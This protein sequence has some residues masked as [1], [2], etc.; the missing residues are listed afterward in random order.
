[1]AIRLT[2]VR[3]LRRILA[4]AEPKIR[5]A[6]NKEIHKVANEILVK[7]KI[8][9]PL[10]DTYLR[11]SGILKQGGAG[12]ATVMS[13]TVEFGGPAAPYALVQHENVK[14]F[15]PAKDRGGVGPGTQGVSRSAKYLEMPAKEA[16][17]TLV[18]RMI[19]AIKAVT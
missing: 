12:S 6:V 4:T 9:V 2:G 5:I 13:Q 8:L 16:Q 15:H 14:F 19:A 7:S 18:P 1:M 10:H 3:D 17:A 11:G